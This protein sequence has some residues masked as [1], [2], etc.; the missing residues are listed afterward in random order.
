MMN[1]DV[2]RQK[3][4][5]ETIRIIEVQWPSHY[6]PSNCPVHVR[7]KLTMA[8]SQERVWAWLTR[9]TLW[10]TWYVNSTNVQIL[11]GPAPDLRKGT[12]FRWK[13]FGVTLTSTVLEYIPEERIAWD[14]HA[15]GIDA[16]HAWV[17]QPSDRGCC[18]L[19]EETQHGWLAI[20]GKLLMPKRTYRF[21]QLWLEGLERKASVSLPPPV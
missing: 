21:H 11:E 1:S 10:P 4:V 7:N 8:A 5:D 17:L 13:T 14:A 2:K 9:A 3:N 15:S 18:V 6:E 16:Y 20:L 12:R 19:T